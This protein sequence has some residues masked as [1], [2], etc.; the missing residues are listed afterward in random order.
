L[1]L[2]DG[3]I[4]GIT[5]GRSYSYHY[6]QMIS[7]CTIDIAESEIGNEVIILWGEPGTRQKEIRA[8]VARFPYYN[9]SRNENV[10]VKAL[11][12]SAGARQ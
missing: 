12:K 7:L 9:E 4:I 6:R 3:K 11:L 2:K 1:V 10:D 8:T 5:A